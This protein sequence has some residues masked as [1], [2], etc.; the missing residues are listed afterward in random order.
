M[1]RFTF[2]VLFLGILVIIPFAICGEGMDTLWTVG[3]LESFGKWAWLVGIGLLVGD[4]LLPMPSTVVMSGLGYVYG[5]ALGGLLASLGALGS[6]MLGYGLCRWIGEPMVD[7]LVGRAGLEQGRAVFD[8]HGPWLVAL[9]RWLPIMAEVVACTAGMARM[10]CKLFAFA[11]ICGCVPMGFGFAWVGQL[12]EE[13]PWM[14]LTVSAL[15]PPLLW[16]CV[17]RPWVRNCIIEK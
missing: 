6:A 15:G 7:R 5:V 13:S 1:K 4:L 9:S 14:A 8:R 10:R 2:L 11:A 16:F 17:A 12:G 3:H